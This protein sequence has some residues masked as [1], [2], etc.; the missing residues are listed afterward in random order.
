MPIRRRSQ[1]A[2]VGWRRLSR[3]GGIERTDARD[4]G[5]ERLAG[6]PCWAS[7]AWRFLAD[8]AGRRG[9]FIAGGH[10]DGLVMLR[11]FTDADHVQYLLASPRIGRPAQFR[12]RPRPCSTRRSTSCS[13]LAIG[14]VRPLRLSRLRAELRDRDRGQ[15][16]DPGNV[17]FD[18]R[19]LSFAGISPRPQGHGRRRT[20]W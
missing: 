17:D 13:A 6:R 12:G 19:S 8:Q 9:C 11:S 7:A 16:Q 15:P 2:G 20:R 4:Q 1:Q 14:G 3:S 10:E 5:A 18:E